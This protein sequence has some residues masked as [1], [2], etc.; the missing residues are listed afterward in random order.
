[1][2]DQEEKFDPKFIDL[3]PGYPQKFSMEPEVIEH[4]LAEAKI[5]KDSIELSSNLGL[6]PIPRCGGFCVAKD[7]RLVKDLK[8]LSTHGLKLI[9]EYLDNPHI[10]NDLIPDE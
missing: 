4:E 8:D 5:S 2:S 1:M 6:N 3:V 10:E 9:R 7:N